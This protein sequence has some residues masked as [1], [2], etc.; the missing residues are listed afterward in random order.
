R[1]EEGHVVSL[2]KPE[3]ELA[4]GQPV[5]FPLF[6]STV[7]GDDEAGQI[8]SLA[9]SQLMTLPPLHTILRGGKKTKAKRTPVT[10]EARC[11]EI[12]TLE[13]YCLARDGDNRWR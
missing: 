12:G 4:I 10:L 5:L 7:R 11:T 3:L 8:L 6:T 13:L 1:L 2:P 9:P